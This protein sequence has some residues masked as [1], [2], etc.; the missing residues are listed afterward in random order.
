MNRLTNAGLFV[1]LGRVSLIMSTVLV[2]SVVGIVIDAALHTSPTFVLIGF[3]VG[4][5]AA[6][7]GIWLFIRAGVRRGGDSGT[8]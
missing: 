4:N 7:I 3:A 8:S 5:V 2:A 1:I 6:F